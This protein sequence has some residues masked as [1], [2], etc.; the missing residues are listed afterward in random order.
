[1]TVGSANNL[2]SISFETIWDSIPYP[3]LILDAKHEIQS[4]NSAAE[5]HFETSSD[6]MTNKLLSSFF[7]D[8][9]LIEDMLKQTLL[10]SSLVVVYEV[11]IF[12]LNRIKIECNIYAS[13]VSKS[14]DKILLLI[15][16]KGNTERMER[17]LSHQAAVRSINGLAVMLAHELR[18]P[19]AGISGAAQ[20]LGMSLN[21]EDKKLS[22]LIISETKRIGELIT[23]FEIFGD[24]TPV[25]KKFINIHDVLDKAKLSAV[26]G[27]AS[28]VNI[29]EHYDPS[30]PLIKGNFDSLM[31]VFLNLLKNSSE[32]LPKVNACLKISTS[33][34]PGFKL[35][36][37][38]RK[39]V[40]LPI[41]VSVK[42]NGSG[43]DE[44]LISNIFEPFVTS[45]KTGSGLGL[46]LVSKIIL[47]HGGV[48]ECKVE[49]GWT[50][51]LIRLPVARGS[52]SKMINS[53]EE[54]YSVFKWLY[55]PDDYK[56]NDKKEQ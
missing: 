26:A 39:S 31:Q 53:D 50:E 44:L 27:F 51:F 52:D 41:E 32:A 33:F 37:S 36:T 4:A 47:D 40:R 29:I 25:I 54:P 3:S 6:R 12:W 24:Q 15:H 7:G 5:F 23:K 34:K 11:E 28:H 19:L 45:K 21:S 46:S 49:D 16:P 17:S 8:N 43:V 42:D 30:L 35:V 48:I 55:Q 1:M 38:S 22:D 20:L 9:N 18:N 10:K 2:D 13:P 14:E 56:T